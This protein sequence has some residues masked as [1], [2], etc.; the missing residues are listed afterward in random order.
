LHPDSGKP[1]IA[2]VTEA[3]YSFKLFDTYECEWAIKICIYFRIEKNDRKLTISNEG[4]VLH[5]KTF[6]I[7]DGKCRQSTKKATAQ[8]WQNLSD[9]LAL[10]VVPKGIYSVKQNSYR[11]STCREWRQRFN[12]WTKYFYKELSN[13]FSIIIENVE[14]LLFEYSFFCR[15]KYTEM[16]LKRDSWYFSWWWMEWIWRVVK[17]LSNMWR[18]DSD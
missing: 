17:V 5:E 3:N 12:S 7:N 18:R 9:K 4:R 10:A 15:W 14:N 2:A 13:S 8:T 11:H 1:G 16:V 6:N